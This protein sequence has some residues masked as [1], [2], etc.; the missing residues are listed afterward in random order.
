VLPAW[1]VCTVKSKAVGLVP[2]P[3][4][5]TLRWKP[6]RVPQGTDDAM[7]KANG[8]ELVPVPP[9]GPMLG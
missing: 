5:V 7:L 4:K 6:R 3:L 2:L 1:P 9:A 8:G